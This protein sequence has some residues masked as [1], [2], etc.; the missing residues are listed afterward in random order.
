V[1]ARHFEIIKRPGLIVPEAALRRRSICYSGSPPPILTYRA[2]SQ[3]G[4]GGTHTHSG[5][6][7]GPADPKRSIIVAFTG[8]N[9]VNGTV[10]SVTIGGVSASLVVRQQS[11]GLS[12]GVFIYI[13]AVPNGTSGSVVLG[14]VS[15]SDWG[16]SVAVYSVLN[17][18]SLIA[19]DTGTDTTNVGGSVSTS[20]SVPSNG[21]VVSTSYALGDSTNGTLSGVVRDFTVAFSGA[22]QS[23]GS[24]TVKSATTL[25]TGA[26]FSGGSG[27]YNPSIATASFR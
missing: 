19:A 3:V 9:G 4:G 1:S 27:F 8:L 24:L 21:V 6:T 7:F 10:S 17:L 18:R 5:L 15:A 2:N 20:V 11:Q 25:T 13:A 22:R 26:S 14:G 23:A 16:S 12:T